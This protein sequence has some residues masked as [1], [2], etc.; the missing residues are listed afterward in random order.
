[1]ATL[2]IEGPIVI[3]EQPKDIVSCEG[4]SEV[5]SVAV[6]SQPNTEF[7]YEWEHSMDNG[8]TWSA[9]GNFS[10]LNVVSTLDNN[11]G[12]YR[13]KVYTAAC[14]EVVS[15][16]VSLTVQPA[17]EIFDQPED[18]T[19]ELGDNAQFIVIL[20]NE[21]DYLYQWQENTGASWIDLDESAV[22]SGVST[23]TLTVN[24]VL[25]EMDE[26]RYRVQIVSC[27][28][29]VTSDSAVLNIDNEKFPDMFS[30][31]GDGINDTYVV[32]YLRDYPDFTMEIYDRWGN[33]VYE[34][35]GAGGSEPNWWNGTSKGRLNYKEGE[36]LPT[37]TYYYTVHYDKEGMKA[38]KTGWVYLRR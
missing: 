12:L 9:V 36:I 22:Y 7:L 10:T 34:V 23:N 28:Q 15:E 16:E 13:V 1:M 14:E 37:G 32:P 35:R 21:G 11:G 24:G 18:V 4:A 8:L 25:L 17:V 33:M 2:Y 30:P 31:N 5:F 29:I 38:P 6:E 20:E 19:V 27:D 3:S 26:N